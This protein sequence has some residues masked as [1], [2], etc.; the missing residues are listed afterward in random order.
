MSA[1][2]VTVDLR[3]ASSQS[4]WIGD[5]QT[6]WHGNRQL[7]AD[8]GCRQGQGRRELDHLALLHHRHRLQRVAL[9]ALLCDFLKTS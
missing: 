3:L 2:D 9:A 8:L 1:T 5:T 4:R 7:Q 6:L